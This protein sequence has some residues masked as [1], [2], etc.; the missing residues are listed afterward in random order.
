MV[1]NLLLVL[2]IASIVDGAVLGQLGGVYTIDSSQPTGGTN[3]VTFAA[4]AADLAIF[5]VIAPV[6]F[7]VVPSAS[8]YAGFTIPGPV[9]GS[10][11]ANTITF[12]GA[13]GVFMAGAAA[14]FTQVVR[15]GPTTISTTVFGG[16]SHVIIDGFDITVPATG[17]GVIVTGSTSCVVRNCYV[18][19]SNTGAG[20]AIVNSNDC[21]VENNEVASTAATPGSPGDANY[22]GGISCFYTGTGTVITRNKVHDCTS[23]GIFVGSSGSTSA[24]ADA[25]VTNNF[26]WACTGAGTFPGGIALRR[27]SGNSVVANNSVWMTT[28]VHGGIHQMGVAADPQPAIIANNIVKHDGT[29]SCFRFEGMTTV[30]SATFDHNLYDPGSTASVGQVGATS[31]STLLAW[32]AVAAPNLSGKEVNTI[33]AN[34][35]YTLAN[36]LHILPSSPAFNS[37]LLVATI[38]DDIDG[39]P[40][41]LSGA[42][43]RGADEALGIGLVAAFSVAPIA[44]PAPL[45][46]IFTDLSFSSS[47]GGITSWAWDFENDGTIDSMGQSPGFT[48]FCPGVYSVSLTVNDGVN[49]PSVLLQSGLITVSDQPFV[50]FTTGGGVGDLLIAPVPTTCY[51]STV[52]GWTLASFTALNP[53]GGGPFGGLY[54]DT[55]TI[56]FLQSP[57]SPGDP[58]HF[59][60]APFLYPNVPLNVGAGA[61]SHFAGTAIDAM[62]VLCGPGFGILRITNVVRITF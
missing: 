18:H 1:K 12:L 52:Q 7:N 4:A 40:R 28:G 24:P 3:Y 22:C 6:T 60:P 11:A 45:A 25:K 29:G 34:P 46:V 38:T 16:P 56:S 62:Q 41:P 21:V 20:I 14:G 10:S 43:D 59:L 47:P 42:Y 13:P 23:Q 5:G 53:V 15:L 19:G 26:V 30:P 39:H 32:Q 31:Y 54:P 33:V 50:M 2:A 55:T 8:P 37:G 58:I 44:G 35:L 48:Y 9:A 61:Y 57:P 36:D 17:A 27:L 51:P 49:P